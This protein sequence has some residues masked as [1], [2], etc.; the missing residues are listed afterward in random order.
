MAVVYH[1]K[2]HKS[3]SGR[4]N[5]IRWLL[6]ISKWNP[7]E[8]ERVFTSVL[9]EN[10]PRHWDQIYELAEL[11]RLHAIDLDR[12]VIT[13]LKEYLKL[14]KGCPH[15]IEDNISSILSYIKECDYSLEVTH[16]KV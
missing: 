7:K 14:H 16:G 13:D 11:R 6:S 5:K 12:Q 15:Y 8:M 2:H 4:E 9:R 3:P 1:G 10:E